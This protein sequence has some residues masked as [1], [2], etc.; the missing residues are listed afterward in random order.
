MFETGSAVRIIPQ[1]PRYH[2]LTSQWKEA[3]VV[4]GCPASADIGKIRLYVLPYSIYPRTSEKQ[5]IPIEYL[6]P[7]LPNYTY[8]V[9]N[10]GSSPQV[11]STFAE[12]MKYARDIAERSP[13]N[14]R[15]GI[16]REVA[17]MQ[18]YENQNIHIEPL[19]LDEVDDAEELM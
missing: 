11:F 12:A 9:L 17:Y 1:Y 2:T 14:C 19:S 15:F 4:L 16:Y 13:K 3:L 6:I 7:D 5:E 8:R 10:D 18:T